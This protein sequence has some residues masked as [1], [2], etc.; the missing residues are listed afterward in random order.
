MESQ[1]EES[2]LLI[3]PVSSDG[4]QHASLD[5]R[6]AQREG[7]YIN[8]S[9]IYLIKIDVRNVD[10]GENYRKTQ[11]DGEVMAVFKSDIQRMGSQQLML[12]YSNGKSGFTIRKFKVS[13]SSWNRFEPG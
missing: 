8:N 9:C 6:L 10:N 2:D 3:N 1:D 13:L 4:Q 11:L 12:A 7:I 5:L